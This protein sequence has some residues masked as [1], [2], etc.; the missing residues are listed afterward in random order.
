LLLH[1]EE[2]HGL[3]RFRHAPTWDGT[4]V[5]KQLLLKALKLA[6]VDLATDVT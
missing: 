5:D 1:R 4:L 3:V 6:R 2:A